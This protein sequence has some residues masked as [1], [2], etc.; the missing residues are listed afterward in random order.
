MLTQAEVDV[1]LQLVKVLLQ[2]EPIDFPQAGDVKQLELMSIDGRE[3]F[4]IDINRKGKIKITKCT[5][6][7]RYHVIEILLRLDIDGPT[8]ENPDGTEVA[9]PHLHIYKEGYADKWAYLLPEGRFTDTTN[10]AGT[11]TDFLRYCNV[12]DIP[13]VQGGFI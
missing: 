11:L 13:E 1:L 6:Q 9:C 2:K 4:L 3:S 10:L 12:Q 7:E 5:Y 8:H